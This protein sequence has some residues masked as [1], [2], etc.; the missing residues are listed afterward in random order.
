[1]AMWE[2][3]S[4]TSLGQQSSTQMQHTGDSLG[5]SHQSPAKPCYSRQLVL[6]CVQNALY[7]G[8]HTQM[9]LCLPAACA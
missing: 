2:T 6:M 5:P 4:I 8:A 1:M 7:M 3:T 9:L